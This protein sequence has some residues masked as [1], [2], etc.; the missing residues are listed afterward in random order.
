MPTRS[1]RRAPRHELPAPASA[2]RPL[3]S[4]HATFDRTKYAAASNLDK[5]AYVL[6]DAVPGDPEIILMATGSEVGLVVTAY[7]EL[8][9]EGVRARV[10]SMPSWEL[11][12]RQPR[13]YRESVLPAHVT[14]RV[15]VEQASVFGW[16][17]YVGATGEMV[18]MQ[19]FGASAPLK[20]VEQKFGFTPERVIE[21]ARAQLARS[22]PSGTEG[23]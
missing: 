10:V 17:R 20:D 3:A 7:E 4:E 12:E 14:A 9:S 1:L 22:R 11:F 23:T 15:G 16:D 5:G 13:T 8:A 2:P 6:A 21:A 18:G 19:T